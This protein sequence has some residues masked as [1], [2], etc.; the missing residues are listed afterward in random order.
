M[1]GLYNRIGMPKWTT[2]L[3]LLILPSFFSKKI[4]NILTARDFSNGRKISMKNNRNEKNLKS[5]YAQ[6]DDLSI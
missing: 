1:L 2:R 4:E 5:L 6:A 3:T